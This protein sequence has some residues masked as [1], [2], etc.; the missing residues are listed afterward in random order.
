M[1][2]DHDWSVVHASVGEVLL[3]AGSHADVHI[4]ARPTHEHGADA[5][6][7]VAGVGRLVSVLEHPLHVAAGAGD[8]TVDG[9][10]AVPHHAT[11]ARSHGILGTRN[12]LCVHIGS[13]RSSSLPDP[14][15][16][17]M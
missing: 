15:S 7:L 5:A 6:R 11:A 3:R 1:R 17:P 9:H 14:R 8:E 4:V 10:G 16:D 13:E 12:G 2:E